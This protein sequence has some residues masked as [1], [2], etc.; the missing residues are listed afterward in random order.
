MQ[1]SKPEL[2]KLKTSQ[3]ALK[4]YYSNKPT[5][6][7]DFMLNLPFQHKD[8]CAQEVQEIHKLR[9]SHERLEQVYCG[10]VLANLA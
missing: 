9:L 3:P 10:A 2:R 5:F 7:M 8:N 4:P 1:L 6:K